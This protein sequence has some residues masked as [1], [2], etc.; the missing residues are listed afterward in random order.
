MWPARGTGA[1]LFHLAH[2]R[3][4]IRGASSNGNPTHV[5][6]SPAH[7]AFSANALHGY[8]ESEKLSGFQGSDFAISVCATYVD[9]EQNSPYMGVLTQDDKSLDPSRQLKEMS[10]VSARGAPATDSWNPSGRISTVLTS[11]TAA[12]HV[13]WTISEWGKQDDASVQT[14]YIN[15]KAVS[16]SQYAN[17][18]DGI[19]LSNGYLRVGHWNGVRDDMDFVGRIYNIMV[20]SRALS[21]TEVKMVYDGVGK[22]IV[23]PVARA[24][25]ETGA[26]LYLDASDPDA[27]SSVWPAR[28]TGAQ[29]FHL[30]HDR[31]GIRGASS[32]G[33]PTHV[34][35][36]PAHYAFSANALHGYFESEKL[37][38]FQGSDFAISVCATYVDTEQN[39]PYMGVLTQD[40]KSLDPSRQLKEM[41]FVSARGAPATDSW[42]PSGRIS[43]VLTSSTA[44]SHVCWTISEWGKQDDASVQT[45]YINGKAVSTSQYANNQDGISLSNGYL[46]V[47]HWNG[48]RDDMDFVGRIYNIMVWSRALSATEV[49]M[50][51]DGV[52]KPIVEA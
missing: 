34:T 45:I 12:S 46:R 2:D 21:A 31:T 19:S 38:G 26:H 16:T 32:N 33:N 51:Y 35:T 22:P 18:Q 49:K 17:N 5:T 39:S 28:G 20:W 52:G 8:F 27:T 10:F 15:G 7:Y 37:S 43:T 4:G 24:A 36:S 48:V 40:D 29:L 1:Q 9:T 44:A 13:C 41:S 6:T 3:T 42:N 23:F 25:S 14:I 47:G 30:A 11:S 50:V